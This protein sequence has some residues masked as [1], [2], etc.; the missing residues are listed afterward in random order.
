MITY[1]CD[2]ETY[3]APDGSTMKDKHQL[4]TG[5]WFAQA[6][7]E[8]HQIAHESYSMD[9]FMSWVFDQPGSNFIFHNLDGFDGHFILSWLLDHD[10]HHYRPDKAI[11]EHGQTMRY[12]WK[13]NR[14]SDYFAGDTRSFTIFQG[15]RSWNFFDSMPLMNSSL[16]RIGND[17]KIEGVGKG[18]ETPLVEWGSTLEQTPHRDED[19]NPTDTFWTWEEAKAYMDQDTLTLA[20]GAEKFDL[21]ACLENGIR[22]QAKLAYETVYARLST[23]KPYTGEPITNVENLQ[24]NGRLDLLRQPTYRPAHPGY[25][26]SAKVKKSGQMVFTYNPTIAMFKQRRIPTPTHYKDYSSYIKTMNIVNHLTKPAYR[27]GFCWVNTTHQHKW[28]EEPGT[29][30]DINSMYPDIYMHTPLV[31]DVIGRPKAYNPRVDMDTEQLRELCTDKFLIIRF[32][33]LKA[34]CK[35]DWP[36][37]IKPRTDA[38]ATAKRLSDTF[39]MCKTNETYDPVI[40]YPITLT[41]EDVL[42]LCEAYDI[43][44]AVVHH[45]IEY[46]RST[47]LENMF[48]THGQHWSHVKE[49]ADG[50]ERTYAKIMLNAPYGKLGQYTREYPVYEYESKTY[51]T[52]A[53]K[54]SV[55]GR[56]NAEVAA[57][58][59]ITARGRRFLGE[60][61]HNIGME[62][63]Y[64]CDTDSMHIRGHWTAEQLEA[65]GLTIHDK[66]FGA[67]KIEGYTAGGRYIQPKTYGEN[68]LVTDHNGVL[69]GET[70]W[71]TTTA[72]LTRQVPQE[73]FHRG[74]K[75]KDRRTV[76]VS[77]GVVLI[78]VDMEIAP[79]R[80][81]RYEQRADT[82]TMRR[83]LQ[84]MS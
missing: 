37:T 46:A 1:F 33:H 77:G 74:M 49:N 38:K 60:S 24:E 62:N 10:F 43:E 58:A 67:W 80:W 84:R 21:A 55:G 40:D 75:V 72:G 79:D 16:R 14:G 63:F 82:P 25:P 3:V 47:E 51:E 39:Y 73:N 4:R 76:K 70:Q 59:L 18:D 27:G 48:K 44:S 42:Y 54:P 7:N 81:G 2:F 28:I 17:L 15:E 53:S 35:P 19:G 30:L 29:I 34:Q 31:R 56:E 26:I 66:K 68:L 41:S 50:Y 20:V 22:T 52:R 65:Q 45:V 69:T 61:I 83:I 6:R 12:L 23:E 57:A 13:Q 78:D 64:Y 9:E 71:K 5:V 36:P 11:N 32:D 8:S